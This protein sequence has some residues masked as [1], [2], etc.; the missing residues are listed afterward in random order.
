MTTVNPCND[1]LIDFLI[2]SKLKA[3]RQGIGKHTT[4]NLAIESVRKYP[5]PIIC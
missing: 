2:A 4:Y 5:L 3:E 1:F